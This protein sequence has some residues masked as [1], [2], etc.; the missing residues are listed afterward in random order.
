[1]RRQEAFTLV[2]LFIV[3]AVLGIMASIA[4][5]A[6]SGWLP[7]YHL[8]SAADD[9]YSELQLT[10]MQAIRNNGEWAVVFNAGNDTYQVVS[11]GADG[12]YST[13]GD[14]VVDK[15][16]DLSQYGSGAA[17]G[18]GAA[19]AA[20]GGGGFDNG[21]TFSADTVVFNSRGMINSAAG[22]YVYLR[23]N[24]NGAYAAG[25]LGSGVVLLKKWNGT[26]WE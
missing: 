15:T 14:N 5:P 2:E 6:F 13:A 19:T 26:A 11:G 3:L 20:I 18:N 7:G 12:I 24:K 17:Y 8:R 10:K 25:V 16:V 4:I 23:N 9:L 22:G 21:I 1:M